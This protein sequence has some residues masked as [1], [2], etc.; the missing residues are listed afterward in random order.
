MPT[1]LLLNLS[2]LYQ[3]LIISYKNRVASLREK[4]LEPF[5]QT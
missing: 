3:V 1:F 2:V 5:K 4:I